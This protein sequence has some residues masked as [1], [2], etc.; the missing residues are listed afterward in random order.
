MHKW[1]PNSH[2]FAAN[3][4]IL[5]RLAKETPT[6]FSHGVILLSREILYSHFAETQTSHTEIIL[7][8]ADDAD[9]RRA[10]IVNSRVPSGREHSAKPSAASE[11]MQSKSLRKS[12]SSACQKNVTR[13]AR[14][15]T[16]VCVSYRLFTT[17]LIPSTISVTLKLMSSPRRL[18]ISLR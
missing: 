18:S 14:P 17:R 10:R 3:I 11:A 2:L 8:H 16:I 15:K 5:S 4:I 6:F 1:W 12:A 13:C 7:A 9:F